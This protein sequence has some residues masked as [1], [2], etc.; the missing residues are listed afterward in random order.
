MNLLRP[1]NELSTLV[2]NAPIEV[3]LGVAAHGAIRL[4]ALGE[5]ET[6]EL[7]VEPDLWAR[8]LE[9]VISCF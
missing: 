1:S 2:R 4:V 8:V 6:S 3:D 5:Q 7:A 9:A